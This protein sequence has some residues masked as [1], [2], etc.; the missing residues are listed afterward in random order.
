M[1]DVR[2]HTR[3]DGSIR[4]LS[5]TG[6]VGGNLSRTHLVGW[7]GGRLGGNPFCQYSVPLTNVIGANVGIVSCN[8]PKL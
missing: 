7:G 3:V 8:F 4:V 5:I 6:N 2:K 1:L